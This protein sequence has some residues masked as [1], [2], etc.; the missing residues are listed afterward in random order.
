[1]TL[2]QDT[3]IDSVKLINASKVDVADDSIEKKMEVVLTST[4]SI[5]VVESSDAEEVIDIFPDTGK[6]L[7]RL[8]FGQRRNLSSSLA[9]I[10]N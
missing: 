5:Q 7:Q 8:L 9:D 1:M 6:N 3:C 2:V 10:K 4:T